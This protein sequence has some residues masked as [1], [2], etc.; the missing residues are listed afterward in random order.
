MEEMAGTKRSR[1][2]VTGYFNRLDDLIE[3]FIERK[4]RSS[5]ARD[6]EHLLTEIENAKND[7]EE[8]II[9]IKKFV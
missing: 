5:D 1:R 9:K 8:I 2:R 6:M 7:A 3:G 4:V